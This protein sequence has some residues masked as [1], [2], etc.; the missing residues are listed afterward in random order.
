MLAVV[1]LQIN[2]N[3]LN[4]PTSTSGKKNWQKRQKTKAELVPQ[5]LDQGPKTSHLPDKH[6]LEHPA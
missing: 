4:S 2:K 1:A 6:P 3:L 5:H